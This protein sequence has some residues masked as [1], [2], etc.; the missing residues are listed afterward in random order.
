MSD[1]TSEQHGPISEPIT[2]QQPSPISE[3]QL[4]NV[5]ITNT[6]LR[7]HRKPKRPR[8]NRT[9]W[10][11]LSIALW[12]ACVYVFYVFVL[13]E[14]QVRIFRYR[15]PKKF[16]PAELGLVWSSRT[17]LRTC[18]FLFVGWF[19]YFGAS[20][21]SF[22]NVVAGRMPEG[23]TIVFG[24]SKCPFCNTRLS[25]FDNSPVLGWLLLQGRCRTCRL[26]IAPRY[27]MIEI[28]V[29]A[30][31]VWIGLWEL[32]RSGANL[33]HWDSLGRSGL[34]SLIHFPPWPLVTASV[35]HAALFAVLIMLAVA[36]TGRLPF[37]IVPS[38]V[39]A[40]MLACPKVFDPQ[41]DFVAWSEPFRRSI[42]WS[43]GHCGNPVLSILIGGLVGML[44][45]WISSCVTTKSFGSIVQRHWILQCFLTGSV[46]GWQSVVIIVLLSLIAYGLMYAIWNS[47]S[48]ERQLWETLKRLGPSI[49]LI[50][51]CMA[52][53][54]F[55]RQIAYLLGIV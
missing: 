7:P 13:P 18:E 3:N 41:L 2:N 33:P 32:F 15:F 39:I 26:P 51:A 44:L 25:F 50:G 38:L 9:N 4:D 27:L 37:P 30:V 49:F 23:R 29:G 10:L 16:V 8:R 53:H 46:L 24:G 48:K 12:I 55:W 14:I 17:L 43:F 36:N 6:H 54:S 40:G 47:G 5:P 22:L 1:Q 35:E 21:G 11:F 52:H 19:F 34:S 45:G 42:A 28:A 20:I 31:F